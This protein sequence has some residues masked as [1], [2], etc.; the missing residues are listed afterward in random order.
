MSNLKNK[1]LTVFAAL[2][3]ILFNTAAVFADSAPPPENSPMADL[4]LPGFIIIIVCVIA[5]FGIKG[6]RNK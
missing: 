5:F 1:T 2:S 6:M 3:L 4:I